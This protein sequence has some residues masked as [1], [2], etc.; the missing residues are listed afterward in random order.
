LILLVTNTGKLNYSQGEKHNENSK[1]N[2]N[3]YKEYSENDIKPYIETEWDGDIW[4]VSIKSIDTENN[5]CTLNFRYNGE[6]SDLHNIKS[7]AF[8][9]GNVNKTQ[10]I[11]VFDISK[12]NKEETY[13]GEYKDMG[14]KLL[15]F[16][17]LQTTNFEAEF[18]DPLGNGEVEDLFQNK[19]LLEINWS[20]S[21]FDAIEKKD[22][23]NIN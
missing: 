1:H 15:D 6:L 5:L 23:I 7:I 12:P 22:T 17:K 20:Y 14:I 16:K 10:I 21:F 8:A 9:L 18:D 2:E 4:Y 3:E 13:E 11:N 19:L